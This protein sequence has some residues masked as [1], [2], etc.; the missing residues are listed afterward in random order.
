MLCWGELLQPLAEKIQHGPRVRR[1]IYGQ[2]QDVGVRELRVF[3]VPH[4]FHQPQRIDA[5]LCRRSIASMPRLCAAPFR[6][7]NFS[8]FRT[9]SG[10]PAEW[11][12]RD[13]AF[14]QSNP[15]AAMRI[16]R[17]PQTNP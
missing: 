12:P 1:A 6:T 13:E 7:A 4:R 15:L 9:T 11:P 14:L 8:R 2:L 3:R 5:R 17:R 16:P 10:G